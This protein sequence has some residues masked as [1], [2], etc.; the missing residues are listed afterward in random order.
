MVLHFV[1][2]KVGKYAGK[3]QPHFQI[4]S[5]FC[6]LYRSAMMHEQGQFYANHLQIISNHVMYGRAKTW[7]CKV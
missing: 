4:I 6:H 5:K 2:G 7:T 3:Q 1:L